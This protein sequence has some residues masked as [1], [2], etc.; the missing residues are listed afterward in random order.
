[1]KKEEEIIMTLRGAGEILGIGRRGKW[2][3]MV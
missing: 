1:M 2:G 3:L